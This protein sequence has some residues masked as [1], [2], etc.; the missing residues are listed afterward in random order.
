MLETHLS[1]NINFFYKSKNVKC[2]VIV[3]AL[4]GFLH[5]NRFIFLTSWGPSNNVSVIP[6]FYRNNKK[7]YYCNKWFKEPTINNTY[8]KVKRFKSLSSTSIYLT[9]N[10]IRSSAAV[11]PA[12]YFLFTFLDWQRFLWNRKIHLVYWHIN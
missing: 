3:K 2:I 1:Q 8:T 6:N 10:D 7:N 11:L 5:A 4:L 12:V 9:I